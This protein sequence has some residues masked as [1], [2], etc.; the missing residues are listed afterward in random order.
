MMVKSAMIA[1]GRTQTLT[2]KG[3]MSGAQL[4]GRAEVVGSDLSF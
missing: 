1:G 2:C 4:T 3:V